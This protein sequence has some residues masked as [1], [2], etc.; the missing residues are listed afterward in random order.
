[1]L[2]RSDDGV[3][4][5]RVRKS[6]ET[7]VESRDPTGAQVEPGGETN[8]EQD[9]SAAHEDADAMVDSM[10]EEAHGGVQDQAE[11]SATCRNA[12]I[13]GERGS[14]LAQGR[15]TKTD[16][17]IDQC[18]EAIIN[19]VPED[20]P[21]PSPSPDQPAQR[22]N[23]PPSVELEGER[24]MSASRDDGLTSTKTNVSG[25]FTGDEDPRN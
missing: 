13:E 8:V 12:S 9:G 23:E 10:A 14:A 20:P 22:E 3:E 4:T 17:E 19:D 1:M 7:Q 21:D 16:E 2:F 15:S 11:R 18:N 25:P 6:G 24:C 5:R